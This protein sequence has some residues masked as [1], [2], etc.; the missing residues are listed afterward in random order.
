MLAK[1]QKTLH[2]RLPSITT[3]GPGTHLARPKGATRKGMMVF[4]W[5]RDLAQPAATSNSFGANGAKHDPEC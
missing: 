3:S 1:D 2:H 4:V 5:L